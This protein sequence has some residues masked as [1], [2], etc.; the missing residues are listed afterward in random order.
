M[1][2]GAR[3]KIV[4][5]DPQARL[6]FSLR[7]LLNQQADWEVIGEAADCQ[8]LQN[9]LDPGCPDLLLIDWHLEGMPTASLL[10]RLKRRY[11]AMQVIVMSGR[12]ELSS[13]AL[14]NGADGFACK[15]DA[16]EKLLN[17]IHKISSRTESP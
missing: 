8:D 15:A 1:Q 3:V 16:P 14:E 5:A 7:T 10:R 2:K 4:I 9:V 6:R 13:T 12:Q 11:P 17:L